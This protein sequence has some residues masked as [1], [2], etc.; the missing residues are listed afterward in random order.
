MGVRGKPMLNS[1][2]TLKLDQLRRMAKRLAKDHALGLPAARERL[3]VHPPRPEGTELRHADYLHVIAQEHNFSSWPALKLAAETVG[4]DRAALQQRLKMALAHGQNRVV[5]FLLKEHPDLPEGLLGVQIALYDLAAVEA[6]IWA[7]PKA[8]TRKLGPRSPMAH[9]CFSTWHQTHPEFS[10]DMMAIAKLLVAHGADVN[11]S[12]PV[13]PDNDHQ[14]SVLYGAL[15]HANNMRLAKWLLENGADPNDGE[16]LYHA[17]ELGHHEGIDMLI[18]H[19]VDPR[20]TNALLRAMDFDDHVAVRKLI[21]AGGDVNEFAAEEVGGELPWVLPA[22]HQAARRMCGPQMIDVLMEAGADPSLRYNGMTSYGYARVFGNRDLAK[23]IEKCGK[24]PEL[25]P[26]EILLAK[27]ADGVDTNGQF[28]DTALL[29]QTYREMLCTL[30]AMPDKLPHVKQL[31]ALGLEWDRPNREGLTPV[32]LAGWEGLPEVMDYFLKL[33]PDLGHINDYGGTLLSTIIHGSENCPN[34]KERD[35]IACLD[36]ALTEG[37][38]LP[39]RAIDLAGDEAVANF[40]A[41][42]A[43][44]HPG[45]VIE[46]GLG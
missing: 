41:D 6:A 8:A 38:A 37:V 14:L 5:A 28:V 32:Q 1:Q 15:G 34:R 19:G 31:V 29:P 3:R 21:A 44:A 11:D 42:W 9:L 20:G 18:A 16:S 27:A 35:Y 39:R 26:E 46:G 40:L 2:N 30:L 43:E 10:D 36:L 7:D 13:A 22:L 24:A 4:L 12:I 33:K 23:A 17:T 45:Q 25:T